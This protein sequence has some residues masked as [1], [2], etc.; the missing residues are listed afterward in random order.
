MTNLQKM[1]LNKSCNGCYYEHDRTCYW[2][3]LVHGS[4]PK[5]IPTNTF[6]IG[7]KQYNNASIGDEARHSLAIKVISVF[8]GEIIGD[9]SV[10]LKKNK[11]YYK[12]HTSTTRNN[13]PERK[14][15]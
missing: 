12:T 2:F 8:D 15:F 9:K 3:E 5:S 10:P 7:C 14:D 11:H 1:T 4:K 6:D 13:Y